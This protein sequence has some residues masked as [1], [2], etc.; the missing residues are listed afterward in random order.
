MAADNSPKP[1]FI[2][3]GDCGFCTTSSNVLRRVFDPLKHFAIEP[4]QHLDL[5]AYGLTEADCD[6]AAQYV[7]ADG[8]VHA[9]HRAIARPCLMAALGGPVWCRAELASDRPSGRGGLSVGGRKS[10][11]AAGG[12]PACALAAKN[13]E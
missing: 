10:R 9:G 11:H 12:T 1:V 7:R 4:Y 6:A 2:F 5:D 3:D 13:N 8:S